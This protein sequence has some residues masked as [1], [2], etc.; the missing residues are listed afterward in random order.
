MLRRLASRPDWQIAL[1]VT[2][3]LRVFYS[4][5]A[6]ASRPFLHPDLALIHSNA[7]TENLPSP[8]GLHYALLGIW[9]R[10]DT[11]WFLRIAEHGYDRPMA[12]IFYPLYPTAI[13]LAS[14]F[15]PAIVAALMVSTVAAF[16]FFWGL[17]RLADS[18]LTGAGR[19][20]MLLLVAVWPASFA[21]FAGYA[22]SLTIALIVWAVIFA[23]AGRW[24]QAALCGFLA[25]L[26]RP[27]GVLVAVPLCILA[28]GSRR[29]SALA[30][31]LTPLG[32]L[33]YW[34]WLHW[35]GRLSVVEAYRLYQGMVLAPPWVAVWESVRMPVVQHDVLLAI[36]LGL[37]ILVIALNLRREIRFED[38]VFALAV[39]LQMLLY[40]GRPAIGAVRYL[41]PVYPAFL[42]LGNYA[43][44]R[45]N[46]KQ[47][48]FYFGAFGFLNLVW[49]WAFLNWSLVL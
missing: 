46:G 43:Q 41:L 33:G 30:A 48:S 47:F 38:K 49:L 10:F 34:G 5:I 3:G 8:H 32:L 24:W 17:L 40:A 13:R 25:G 14:W 20:H 4:A 44:R 16:F 35:S 9:E 21:L 39:I 1:A 12:V 7:L 42:A 2:A 31:S 45:W 27:S 22:E 18:S 36:R 23:R 19:V 15:M 26:G 11:L 28:L 6:A 29:V 37:I